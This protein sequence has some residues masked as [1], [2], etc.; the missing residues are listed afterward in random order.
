MVDLLQQLYEVVWHEETVPTQW[1][2]GILV[3]FFKKGDKQDFG[4][5]DVFFVK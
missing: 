4:F 5:I 1:T 2:E 3:N